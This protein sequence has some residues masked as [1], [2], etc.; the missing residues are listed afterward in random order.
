MQRASEWLTGVLLFY[1]AYWIAM[2]LVQ[3]AP[4]LILAK[5]FGHRLIYFWYSPLSVRATSGTDVRHTD[6]QP[7]F[8]T[9]LVVLLASALGYV[10][11]GRSQRYAGLLT[12]CLAQLAIVLPMVELLLL[13]RPEPVGVAATLV[14]AVLLWIGLRTFIGPERILRRR[15]ERLSSFILPLAIVLLL[16]NPSSDPKLFS[17]LAAPSV[18]IGL[19]ATL[20]SDR[21][22]SETDYWARVGAGG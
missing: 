10:L 3:A 17:F 22:R 15:L 21:R 18:L 13:R 16:Q 8:L 5:F 11:A 14:Y 20:L 1:P 9:M 12:A 4:Y 19:A 2:F 6:K 7:V